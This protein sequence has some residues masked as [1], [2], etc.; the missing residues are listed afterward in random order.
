MKIAPPR[1]MFRD[2]TVV[3]RCLGLLHASEFELGNL[4][5]TR[6]W[7]QLAGLPV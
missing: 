7:R 5:L 4:R 6:A 2:C 1:E 3:W